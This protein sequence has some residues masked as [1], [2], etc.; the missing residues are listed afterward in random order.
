LRATPT[1]ESALESAR[2]PASARAWPR[3]VRRRE[4]PRYLGE[5]WGVPCAYATL[6]RLAT[7]GG[8]PVFRHFGR[9]VVY[10]TEDLDAWADG[11]LTGRK[12]STSDAAPAD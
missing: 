4:A 8:G 7:V 2:A 5:V 11:K 12:R 10:A 9:A 6:M 1:P 3:F